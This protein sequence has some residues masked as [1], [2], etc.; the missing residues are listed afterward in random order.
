MYIIDQIEQIYDRSLT[1]TP[2]EV[3]AAYLLAN[4][5]SVPST[6][7]NRS[8]DTVCRTAAS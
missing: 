8:L 2:D 3:T 1:G 7:Q 5:R 6:S 4:L